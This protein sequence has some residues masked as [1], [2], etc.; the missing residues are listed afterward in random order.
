MTHLHRD[1]PLNNI[2]GRYRV[3]D[4]DPFHPTSHPTIFHS[5]QSHP[6]RRAAL[7]QPRTTGT[8]PSSTLFRPANIPLRTL[9][10]LPRLSD[11][12]SA[13]LLQPT[14]EKPG[15]RH[16]SDSVG[17]DFSFFGDTG[18]LA[19]Q[20]A[21]EEDPL[22]IKLRDSSE[23]GGP[24]GSYSAGPGRGRQ[25]KRVRHIQQDHP[26]RKTTNPGL[27]KEAIQIPEPAQRKIGRVEQIIAIAMT[28]N[29]HSSQTHGLTG[30]PLLY[31]I[32]VS[33]FWE[34]NTDGLQILHQ[35]LCVVRSVSIWIRPGGHV[36]D[37][38]VCQSRQD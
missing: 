21:D 8:I 19:E 17:S 3:F 23:E 14:N 26:E 18:D 7:V 34:G 5:E 36:R 22:H 20:L 1:L 32:N 12:H 28:G 11:E 27:D 13:S 30:K 37:N 10:P 9:I 31:A 4:A 38:H 6:Y 33:V 2:I 16:S 25:P 29:R 15:S 24:G 35:C